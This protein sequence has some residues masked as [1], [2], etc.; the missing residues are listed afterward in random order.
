MLDITNIN[1]ADLVPDSIR[2][3]PDV[4]AAISAIDGELKAV[5]QI[6]SLPTLYARIDSLGSTMLDHIAWQVD[7][8]VWRDSWPLMLKRSTIKNVIVD[9]AKKGTKAALLQ[10]VRSLG[11]ALTV[12]EWWEYS[13]QKTPHTFDVQVALAEIDGTFPEERQKDIILAI[14]DVKPARSLYTFTLATQ[15]NAGL[16]FQAVIRPAVYKRIRAIEAPYNGGTGFQ[17]AIRP[18]S[19]LRITADEDF[20][21]LLFDGKLFSGSELHNQ[22]E[23][24][25]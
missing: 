6:A 14:N 15:A 4:A 21:S 9:K 17:G 12:K 3:D 20:D 25:T 23:L 1:L 18:V 2:D 24:Y 13:T 7:S 10:S 16:G 8:K 11:G 22:A 5:S 19:Y